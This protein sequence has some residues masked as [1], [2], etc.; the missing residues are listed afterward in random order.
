MAKVTVDARGLSCPQPV[1]L[2]MNAFKKPAEEYEILVDNHTAMH[3]VTRYAESAGK[4][5]SVAEN[6]DDIVLTV[7]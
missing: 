2:T 7:R 3:N 1:L 5:V 4:K 6:G